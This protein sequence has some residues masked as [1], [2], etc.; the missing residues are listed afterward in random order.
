MS[1]RET[2]SRNL[3]LLRVA[4]GLSQEA[5]ADS[6]SIAR[7]YVSAL[8]RGRY[9]ASVDRLDKLAAELGVETYVLLMKELPTEVLNS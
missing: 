1:S 7:S 4:R 2:L 3:R 5:L 8:E 9:S 6:A